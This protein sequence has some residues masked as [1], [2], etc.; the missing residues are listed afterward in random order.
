ML[1]RDEVEKVIKILKTDP[2][3]KEI[4]KKLAAGG[5]HPWIKTLLI[6]DLVEAFNKPDNLFDGSFLPKTAACIVKAYFYNFLIKDFIIDYFEE[7]KKCDF[8]GASKD[9]L[10]FEFKSAKIVKDT[11]L[12]IFD[13]NFNAEYKYTPEYTSGVDNSVLIA[14]TLE[15]EFNPYT[16]SVFS[17]S[18]NKSI[19]SAMLSL[20]VKSIDK[21]LDHVFGMS[22]YLPELTLARVKTFLKYSFILLNNY[23]GES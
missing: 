14:A 8:K 1:D 22:Y 5:K 2:E 11:G 12:L 23:F 17:G 6:E 21:T 4:T 9:S 18:I 15:L 19:V 10:D 13:L 16:T 3:Y 7:H 20:N